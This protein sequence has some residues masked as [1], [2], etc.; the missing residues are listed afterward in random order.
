MI[1]HN[2]VQP[3]HSHVW[4]MAQTT[5]RL[6]LPL[7]DYKCQTHQQKDIHPKIESM[8]EAFCLADQLNLKE[9]DWQKRHN[10][11]K[12]KAAQLAPG[13]LVLLKKDAV[14]GRPK[15]QDRWSEELYQ[16]MDHKADDT[17]VYIVTSTKTGNE[18]VVHRNKLLVI[19]LVDKLKENQVP[20]NE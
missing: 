7:S 15:L 13:N 9:M 8:T 5:H 12:C 18:K 2:Q 10:D 11:K 19:Q 17:P 6:L 1:K 4:L 16:V 14:I 20:G 3:I